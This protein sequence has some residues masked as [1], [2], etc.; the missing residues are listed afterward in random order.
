MGDLYL[1]AGIFS[2]LQCG[3]NTGLFAMECRLQREIED[4]GWTAEGRFYNFIDGHPCF[5]VFF[6]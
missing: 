2:T 5:G 1:Q 3:K 4:A 6:G